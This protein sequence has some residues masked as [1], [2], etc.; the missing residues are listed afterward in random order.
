[1]RERMGA[2]AVRLFKDLKYTGAGT[3]EFLVQGEEYFF[4]EVNAR[5]QVE[6]PVSEFVSGVDIIREQIRGCSGDALSVSQ[7]DVRLQ[8]HALE[9]RVNAK[10][11]GRAA[12]YLPPGGFRVRVDSYL[13]TGCDVP[14]Y[15]DSMLAKVIV[16][17]DN[18]LEAI[19]RMERALSEFILEGVPTNIE[20]Q[21]K[22]LAHP[23]FRKGKF[24]TSL[25]AEVMK[26]EKK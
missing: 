14:P 18:R 24:G 17:A 22:I 26:E 15:Y 10:A 21:K 3:I 19:T 6:H 23:T 7:A 4:M 2:D 20:S 11:P 12:L 16:H 25:L 5:V 9:C 8:G 1:M 13:I